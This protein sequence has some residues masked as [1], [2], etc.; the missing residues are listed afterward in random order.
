MKG[1]ST[2]HVIKEWTSKM[3]TL[4]SHLEKRINVLKSTYLTN[5]NKDVT[6]LIKDNKNLGNEAL[7]RKIYYY[8]VD[9]YDWRYWFV[10]VYDDIYG[11][12]RHTIWSC[13]G[14]VFL[15]KHKKNI[16]ISSQD[17]KYSNRFKLSDA[18]NVLSN[19]E[20]DITKCQISKP[21][22][23]ARALVNR[24]RSKTGSSCIPYALVMAVETG[25]R[26]YSISWSTHQSYRKISKR[27]RCCR[28][29]WFFTK[30]CSRTHWKHRI[31]L[32][33]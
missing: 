31:I 4:K 24:A 14:K 32:F 13:G 5:L 21:R 20:K 23:R 22:E 19:V 1:L 12:D 3:K 28:K 33:G 11:Y 29:G 27:Q 17:K 18:N 10:A 15:H 7:M 16:I 9:K 6:I 8:I 2:A 30:K 26:L 25:K